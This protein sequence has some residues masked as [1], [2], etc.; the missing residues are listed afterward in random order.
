MGKPLIVALALAS[1]LSTGALLWL[2]DEPTTAR[3]PVAAPLAGLLDKAV[4]GFAAANHPW[5]FA[6]PADHGAHPAYRTETWHITGSLS[7]RTG[8]RFAFQLAFFRVG[9][10]PPA[11]LLGP[12]AWAARDV[13]WAHFALTDVAAGRFV[14]F[15]QLS[16]AAMGFGGAEASPARVWLGDWTLG[17][18]AAP[19][20]ALELRA[21]QDESGIVLTL[22]NVKPPVTRTADGFHSYL[23]TRLV[24]QGTLRVGTQSFD[25]EGR[26]WLDRAWGEVPLPVGAVVWDRFLLQLDDGRD[27]MV[28]RLRRR[29]GSG[30]PV[31]SGL[32][33]ERD[34]A[35]RR[36]AREDLAMEAL[37]HWSAGDGTRYPTN[38][39]LRLP[40]EAIELELAAW[41]PDQ[42]LPLA[43]R[44]W[45]GAVSATGNQGGNA[46]SGSGHFE[47]PGYPDASPTR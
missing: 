41:L 38:W 28:V 19:G 16:R 9:V 8:R 42:R 39:R 32:L 44:Y 17:A 15:E 45:A 25:V 7:H 46:L 23:M 34:G 35:A 37:A 13:Y 21:T 10:N 14:A 11:A 2:K 24:A 18:Q 26:A 27:L 6:F 1:A 30:Q 22:R 5:R 20:K 40:S 36:L 29:D 31:L 4:D 33:V 43:L 3:T 12:S 47:S